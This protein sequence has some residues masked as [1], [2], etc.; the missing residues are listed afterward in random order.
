MTLSFSYNP[1]AGVVCD[2]CGAMM[3]PKSGITNKLL[4]DHRTKKHTGCQVNADVQVERL[5]R[6]ENAL[7][8][9]HHTL[10]G[11]DTE[12]LKLYMKSW[13]DTLHK[14]FWCIP[15]NRGFLQRSSHRPHRDQLLQLKARKPPAVEFPKAFLREAHHTLAEMTRLFC[16]SYKKALLDPFILAAAAAINHRAVPGPAINALRARVESALRARAAVADASCHQRCYQLNN[17]WTPEQETK[18]REAVK[19]HGEDW[20]AV[21]ALFIGRTNKCCQERWKTIKSKLTPEEDAELM[22]K[23]QKSLQTLDRSSCASNSKPI[24]TTTEDLADDRHNTQQSKKVPLEVHC[25]VLYVPQD[26]Q[27]PTEDDEAS[28]STENGREDPSINQTVAVRRKAAKR[29]LPWDL[30]AGE[31]HIVS[32]TPQA[33]EIPARKKRRIEEHLPT[34]TDEAARNTAASPDLSVGQPHPAVD[35]DNVNADPVPNTQ[36]NALATRA[37]ANWTKDEDAKLINAV[38]NT[39]KNKW[40]N[41]YMTD[42]VTVAALVPGRTTSQCKHRWRDVLNPS[43]DRKPP[44]RS[45]T[46]IED[47]DS[48]LKD[49]VQMHGGKN[50]GAI[51]ALV[52]GR[53]KNQCRLESQH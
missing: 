53:T 27:E 42:W 31:L 14:V 46:W 21:G 28:V 51:S 29:S 20:V 17:K 23:V 25:T 22:K 5:Q 43:I 1:F 12:K 3:D 33:E 44:G 40:G 35:N 32:S 36:P 45:G 41:E 34:A 48:K 8:E 15:C 38:T 24:K 39:S 19:D 47:E 49:A 50:W 37:T 9:L 4:T 13:S 11:E 10:L 6:E 30:K 16:N 2:T 18:L 26:M 52:P 7:A